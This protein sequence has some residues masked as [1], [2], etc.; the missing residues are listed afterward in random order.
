MDI[1][2]LNGTAVSALTSANAGN[3]ANLSAIDAALTTI[4]A[5]VF[6]GAPDLG[7][8]MGIRSHKQYSFWNGALPCKLLLI[9]VLPDQFVTG[10]RRTPEQRQLLDEAKALAKGK[11]LVAPGYATYR[12]YLQ[13]FRAESGLDWFGFRAGWKP[14]AVGDH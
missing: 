1:T 11:S 12:D 5:A 8:R 6:T 14:G 2:A 13:H 7:K 4:N 10:E 3:S 9:K